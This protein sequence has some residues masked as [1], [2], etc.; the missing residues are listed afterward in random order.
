MK[1]SKWH[2]RL[3]EYK[4]NRKSVPSFDE[5]LVLKDKAVVPFIKFDS[6]SDWTTVGLPC[7]VL[8]SL[9]SLSVLQEP[10]V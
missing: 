7:V 5:D 9:T 6:W 3:Y 2:A 8:P 1:Q 4:G 10:S